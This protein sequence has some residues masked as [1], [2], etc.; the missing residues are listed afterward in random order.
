VRQE[1]PD[2][3]LLLKLDVTK[4]SDIDQAVQGALNRYSR[5]DVLV[6]NAGYGL[7]GALEE[8]SMEEIRHQFETNVFG[9]MAMTKA[10]LPVMR[11]Q[12]YGYILNMSSV[13]G[14][15][16]GAGLGMYNSTKFAVEGFSES[17]AQDV[18]SF[19]IKVTIIEPGPFR[20]DFAGQSIHIPSV[21]PD[22]KDSPANRVRAYIDNINAKQSGDP[23][24]AAKIM[25]HI[26]E[27]QDPP[28]RLL[29]GKVALERIQNKLQVQNDELKK[30]VSLTLSADYD[31]REMNI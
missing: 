26:A 10:V 24:K 5:I 29:L 9:L 11:A 18:S 14:L 17:L 4:Q 30:F 28:L 19:G 21:H 1:Y 20:T 27:L 25:I 15:V 16:A 7:A 22:Y 31:S 6:N 2:R 3:L 23:A 12:R 13:A 8:C